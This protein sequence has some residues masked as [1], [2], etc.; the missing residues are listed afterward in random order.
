MVRCCVGGDHAVADRLQ[1][2]LRAFLLLEERVLVELALGD[3]ELDA[4]QAPQPPGA[5]HARLGAADHPAPVAVAV[6]HAV[7]A[8]EDRRLARD[9][10]ADHHLHARH[11][12]RVHQAAPVGRHVRIVL[13]EAE[14]LAPAGREVDGVVLDVEVPQPVV[15]RRQRQRVALL[16]P[17][18]VARDAQALEAGGEARADELEQQVQVRVPAVAR[19]RRAERHET[20]HAA[21]QRQARR[22]AAS[23]CRA[24]R[25]AR[26]RRRNRV[27]GTAC[28]ASPGCAGGRACGRGKA[29]AR[30]SRPS[31]PA[32]RMARTARRS[33]LPAR[34]SS[35]R[36]RRAR[37]RSR[38][39]RSLR[40][41][42]RGC[43]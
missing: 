17:G 23:A 26:R 33:R 29:A 13:V 43:A 1:R 7:H 8:L 20:V 42:P 12:V 18:D 11:V 2:D 6:A 30:S 31:S 16:E 34:R 37:C 27:A 24:R 5:V 25:S 3:V 4:H 14:H 10:V 41:A 15:G 19:L 38:R 36:D 28:R 35:A 9:V 21:V 39:C 32:G 40:A 22:P